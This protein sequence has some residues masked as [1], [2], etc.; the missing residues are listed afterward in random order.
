MQGFDLG[1]IMWVF[2]SLRSRIE[3]WWEFIMCG[4]CLLGVDSKAGVFY[5]EKKSINF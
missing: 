3:H 5:L 4:F 2:V 1:F